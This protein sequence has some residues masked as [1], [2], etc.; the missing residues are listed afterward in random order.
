[1]RLFSFHS[2]DASPN[3]ATL[4]KPRL[5]RFFFALRCR[6]VSRRSHRNHIDLEFATVREI[7]LGFCHGLD[8]VSPS[9]W[10][11]RIHAGRER[12]RMMVMLHPKMAAKEKSLSESIT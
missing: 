6:A 12:L 11:W 4:W 5:W 9:P 1:M 7:G 2:I 10:V 8:V 3:T